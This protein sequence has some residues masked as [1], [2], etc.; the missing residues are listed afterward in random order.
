MR[1]VID[2]TPEG[3]YIVAGGFRYAVW[4]VIRRIT[5]KTYFIDKYL[6]LK[7]KTLKTKING[8]LQ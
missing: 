4:R 3:E 2:I 7:Y 6:N 5:N 8:L 1:R